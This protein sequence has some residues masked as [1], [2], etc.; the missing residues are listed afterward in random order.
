MSTVRIFKKGETLFK[1]GDKA[2]ALY[3]IQTGS[4]N[5]FVTRSKQNRD[6]CTMGSGMVVG[7]H[8]AAGM[9]QHPHSAVATTETKAIELPV[10]LVKSQVDSG[11]QLQKF[12]FKGMIDKLKVIMKDVASMKLDRDPTPCPEEQTAKAFASIFHTVRIK[13]EVTKEGTVSAS[14]PAIRQYAQ[15]IFL[16]PPRRFEMAANIFVKLGWAKYTMGK[17]DETPDSPE[18]IVGITFSDLPLLEQFFEFYQYYYFKGGKQEILKAE[19]RE[20]AIV[21]ALLELAVGM[22]QERNH[23]VTLPYEKVTG[24]V[25]DDLGIQLAGDHWARLETKGLFVKRQSTE[26]G[27]TLQFDLQ[28][29]EKTAKF[30]KILRE[31]DRWNEKGTVDPHEPVEGFK[32]VVVKPATSCCSSCG[33]SYEAPPK[34]CAECGSKFVVA[35]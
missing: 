12:L 31:I 6:L 33:A 3:L 28:E 13:G 29:F 34:F 19:D 30:W 4:V 9:A 26:K 23:T 16:E 2:Q 15:R 17:A 24:K 22:P 11:T 1:E 5:L 7:E 14:W 20:L 25:K 35:A 18:E 27:V 8:A 10:E 32:K 21:Q